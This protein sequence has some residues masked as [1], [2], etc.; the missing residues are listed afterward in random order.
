MAIQAFQNLTDIAL[1]DVNMLK[2]SDGQHWT[3]LNY[4]ANF[5]GGMKIEDRL[6]ISGKLTDKQ[7]LVQH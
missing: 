7:E 3:L 6:S 1:F 2:Y 5:T 4:R